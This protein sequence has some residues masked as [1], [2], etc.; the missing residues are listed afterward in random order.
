MSEAAPPPGLQ[1]VPGSARGRGRV[2]V[3]LSDVIDRGTRRR[4]GVFRRAL[5]REASRLRDPRRIAAILILS[6]TFAM[7][8]SGLIA[9]GEAGGADARAYW[10]GVRIWLNGG[11]PYHPTGPFLPYVYAPWMLPLFAPWALLPWDVAWFVW[12]VGTIVAL[13]WTIHWAYR[14][15]PLTTAVIVAVLGFPF[16]A[17][18]D[19]GNI[20]LQLTLMLWA[21]QF[22]GP[23]L[24][25]LLWA[26]A[27]W[28]KWVPVVFWPILPGRAK[29][30]GLVWLAVSIGL[31]ILTLPL[32]IIQF[33][34]LFG[35]GERPI[36]LDYLVYL[37][38]AV[39]WL[40]RKEDRLDFLRPATWRAWLAQS[41]GFAWREPR[42]A[43]SPRAAAGILAATLLDRMEEERA[44]GEPDRRDEEGQAR[45]HPGVRTR[46]ELVDDDPAD[47]PGDHAVRRGRDVR[48]AHVPPRR[49]LRDDVGHQRPVDREE[50]AP[51]DADEDRPEEDRPDRRRQGADRHA[52]RAQRAG[53][54]DD[55]LPPESLGQPGG[56]RVAAAVHRA[57]T[58]VTASNQLPRSSGSVIPSA[59]SRYGTDSTIRKALPPRMKKR[60]ATRNTKLRSARMS[61]PHASVAIDRQ[62]R[63]ARSLARRP[64][65][66]RKKSESI[67]A[68]SMTPSMIVGQV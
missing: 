49:C 47:E 31:S 54:I 21:A 58:T 19:T 1:P 50:A 65:S 23:R 42:P 22:T 36:R 51:A 56:G 35:F 60:D 12:R 2:T 27:T 32:T 37:W 66:S 39:P 16:A 34:A 48:D 68:S 62:L 33:Q 25:G 53:A 52:R 7:I 44:D 10:A 17:N 18:L 40:Y 45:P 5:R 26:L 6:L 30:W 46:R 14:R 63:P 38:A 24:G 61:V 43:L 64:S 28:M 59:R 8:L 57:T 11:D 13:L 4:A 15:R 9:R 3:D 67:V 41:D 29:R 55:R 20:N